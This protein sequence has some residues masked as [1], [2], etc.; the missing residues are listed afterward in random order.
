MIGVLPS[1]RS[2][3]REKGRTRCG[4]PSP[5]RLLYARC[6]DFFHRR[7]AAAVDGVAVAAAVGP[8]RMCD[9]AVGDDAGV[10]AL[11][12]AVVDGGGGEDA[13]AGVLILADIGGADVRRERSAAA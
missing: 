10:V 3:V 11:L 5:R 13:V 2:S 9:A 6:E 4:P 7:D 8:D 1:M 12:V